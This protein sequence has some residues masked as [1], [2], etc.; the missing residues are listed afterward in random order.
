MII[1]VFRAEVH[2]GKTAEFEQFFRDIAIPKV[3]AHP[4]LVAQHTGRPID[5]GSR[6]FVYISV[7]RD[8][9]ALRGF[10]GDDWTLAVIEPE[11][12]HLLAT[13]SIAHYETLD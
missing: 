5:D 1:R 7:W 10:A 8:V 13:T 3:S 4:G 11:E 12:R 9:E 2:P 6:E